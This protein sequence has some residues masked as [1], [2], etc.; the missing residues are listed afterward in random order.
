MSN[1]S[2]VVYTRISPN[3]SIPR[4]KKIDRITIHHMAGNLSIETCG[5]VFA[6]ASR[7]ASSQ[8]GI[9][10]QGRVGLYCPESDR[11]WCSSSSAN[12]N[13]AV[14]IEV[15][16]DIIGSGRWHSSAKAME[17]LVKL[18]A[19]ICRRNG[20]KKLTYTGNTNGNLTLHRWF[21]ATD[22][23][24]N[25]LEGQMKWI[26]SEVNKLLAG[27]SYSAP[28]GVTTESYRPEDKGYLTLNDYG[29]A[30]KVMQ[31]MLVKCGYSC[32]SAG[33]D[34]SFGNDTLAAV[35]K[36]QSENGLKVDGWYGP[37]SK[38]KLTEIYNAKYK[39][40][41]KPATSAP[42]K[43]VSNKIAED[44]L[45]G[46]ETTKKLQS[47]LGCKIIDGVVSNQWK[48]YKDANPGLTTGWD[49]DD[50]PNGVGSNVIRELQKLI[51]MPAKEIDG[52]VGSYT[53]ATMQRF[54]KC[55]IVDG[56][57]SNPSNCIKAMQKWLNEQ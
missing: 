16:D 17:T 22:C 47:V 6:P 24:G 44:G 20:I 42:A 27:G 55:K 21:S 30:V 35:K 52:E 56:N 32:G 41:A 36:F 10:S 28:S 2:M 23:P 7:D 49:W 46:G 13:R 1:S 45:W 26:A 8:Y 43:P 53:F 19:D 5:N 50:K 14:T 48:V 31:Q 9:D 12:D 15:A 18:C 40:T 54:F 4:N 11:S 51:G 33:I 25:Y 39:A 29:Q 38:A 3:R 57:L 34:G 37:A